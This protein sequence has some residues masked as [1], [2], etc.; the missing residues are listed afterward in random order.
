MAML[1]YSHTSNGSPANGTKAWAMAD[2]KACV[3]QNMPV[4]KD[5]MFFGAL[6]NAYSSPVMLAKIS[7][8]AMRMYAGT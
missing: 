5:R 2:E 4:T 1:M 7:E 6:E 3:N 8:N